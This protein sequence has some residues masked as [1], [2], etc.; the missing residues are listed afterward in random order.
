LNFGKPNEVDIDKMTVEEAKKY[1][2]EGHFPPGSMGPKIQAC[3]RFI[4][5]GGEMAI[6]TSLEKAT[7]ALEG[8]TGT[9]IYRG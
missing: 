1:Y 4:E 7:E 8:K 6:I 5:W 2:E 3:I 9:R